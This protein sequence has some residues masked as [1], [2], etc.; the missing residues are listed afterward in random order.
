MTD[1][2]D[3]QMTLDTSC[4]VLKKTLAYRQS[5]FL[6]SILCTHQK[7]ASSYKQ[8]VSSIIGAGAIMVWLL[9]YMIFDHHFFSD[10]HDEALCCAGTSCFG[11]NWYFQ[12]GYCTWQ[13]LW[14]LDDYQRYA[15]SSNICLHSDVTAFPAL[16]LAVLTQGKVNSYMYKVL[17]VSTASKT[18]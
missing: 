3:Q 12:M 5:Q 4:L 13:L 17:S 16:S 18:A 11:C 10:C 8:T 15:F 9:D 1:R 7:V 14:T 2:H 6:A